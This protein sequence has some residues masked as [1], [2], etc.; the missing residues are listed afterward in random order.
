MK[1][2]TCKSCWYTYDP[3]IGDP[4][5]GIAPG[6][7]FEDLPEDWFCPVCM[8]DKEGFKMEEEVKSADNSPEKNELD[9]YKCPACWYIYDPRLGDPLARIPVGTAFEDLPED[10]FCPICQ[11]TKESFVKVTLTEQIAKSIDRGEDLNKHKD[12]ARYKCRACFYTYDPRVG[13]PAYDIPAGT[14]F[15][16]LPEDWL[17]PI[18]MASKKYFEREVSE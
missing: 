10:W 12:L 3:A 14:A 15:E 1:K 13:D 11:L 18:C 6:T 2:Y 7:P 8:R 5:A 17:C 4:K 16:A 9:R